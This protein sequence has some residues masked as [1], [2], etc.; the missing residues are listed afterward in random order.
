MG[1]GNGMGETPRDVTKPRIAPFKNSWKRLQDTVFLVQFEAR[2]RERL[3]ILPNT[4]ACSRSLQHTICSLQRESGMYENTGGAPPNGSL[5]FKI[6]TVCTQVEFE[7]RSTRSTKPRRKI[8][9][10]PTKR[11]EELRGNL[12]QRR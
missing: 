9:L 3:A 12:E 2:S 8:I 1:D 7:I 4:V 11:F 10:G 5:N 6:A